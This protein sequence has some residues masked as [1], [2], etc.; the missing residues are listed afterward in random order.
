MKFSEDNNQ[1]YWNNI[2]NSCNKK[3]KKLLTPTYNNSTNKTR[4]L[5]NLSSVQ[6]PD[7]VI[8]IISLGSKHSVPTEIS[9]Q[10]V[11]NTITNTESSLRNLNINDNDKNN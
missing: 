11:V 6:I 2:Q 10:Y 5:K 1:L 9:K 4:W 8:D 3:F 7:D